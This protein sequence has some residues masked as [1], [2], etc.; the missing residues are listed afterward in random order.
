MKSY[1][2]GGRFELV[3]AN[4][5][6]PFPNPANENVYILVISD[7]FTKFSEIYPIPNMEAKTIASVFFRGWIKRYGCPREFHSDQGTQFESQVFQHLCSMFG[8]LI[9]DTQ[10][11]FTVDLVNFPVEFEY[12]VTRV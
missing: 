3:A 10:H 12:N 8:I 4:I 11:L 5:V 2:T 6:G 1:I 7:Y 9:A